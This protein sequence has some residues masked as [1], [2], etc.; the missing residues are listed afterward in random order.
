MNS[1][2]TSEL[3]AGTLTS[4]LPSY[5]LAEMIANVYGSPLSTYVDSSIVSHDGNE[6]N[7]N[8][9]ESDQIIPQYVGKNKLQEV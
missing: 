4:H 8:N 5:L 1:N 9:G 7:P 6:R 3:V 2:L